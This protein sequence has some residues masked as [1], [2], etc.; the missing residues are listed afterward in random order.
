M[1]IV[2]GMQKMMRSVSNAYHAPEQKNVVGFTVLYQ[3]SGPDNWDE[4]ETALEEWLPRFEKHGWLDEL[5]GIMVG[6]CFINGR[7]KAGQYQQRDGTVVMNDRFEPDETYLVSNTKEYGLIHEVLHHVHIRDAIG[8]PGEVTVEDIR[9]FRRSRHSGGGNLLKIFEK[10]VS[11]YAGVNI[12][13][14]VAETGAGIIIGEDYPPRVRRAYKKLEGPMPIRNWAEPPE[15][16]N[17][18]STSTDTQFASVDNFT[19][20]DHTATSATS[21]NYRVRFK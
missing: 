8:T 15:Q 1:E 12:L 17:Y 2:D 11:Q 19:F 10:E 16:F 20:K 9:D 4:W 5:N 21:S 7:G 6:E 13:E 3:D 14:A 18:A